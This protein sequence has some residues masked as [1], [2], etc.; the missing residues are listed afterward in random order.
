MAHQKTPDTVP[1]RP[2]TA[3]DCVLVSGVS[4]EVMGEVIEAA[5]PLTYE[6][7]TSNWRGAISGWSWDPSRAPKTDFVAEAGLK[8]FYCVGHWVFKPAGV[9]SAMITGWYIARDILAKSIQ[10]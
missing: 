10:K 8:G 9:P 5:T 1:G 2:F 6:R 4:G 7:Y 3:R